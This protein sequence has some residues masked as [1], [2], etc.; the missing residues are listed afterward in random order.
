MAF[1]RELTF[2][3]KPLGLVKF[4]CMKFIL[5]FHFILTQLETFTKVAV[6]DG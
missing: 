2:P 1:R 5:N 6:D 4:F 3:G